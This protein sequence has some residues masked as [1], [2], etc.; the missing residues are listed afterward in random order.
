MYYRYT[1]DQGTESLILHGD[2]VSAAVPSSHPR[3]AELVDYLR[4]RRDHDAGH[5]RRLLDA[6]GALAARL[7]RLSERVAFDGTHLRFDGD[8]IDT[9][10]SRHIIRMMRGGDESYARWVMFLENLAENQSA[11]SRI[12]LFTWLDGRDFAITPDGHLLGYK[13][14]Q[15][16]EH[17]SS[18]HAGTAIVN[19]TW[20]H[21]HIPN[22]VGATV[23]M[24]RNQVA[25]DRAAGC[26]TGLH[27]GTHAYANGYGQRLLL[28]AVNPRDVVSVPRDCS[29][30]KLRC[31]R[32]T[33]LGVHDRLGPIATPSYGDGGLFPREPERASR[34]HV[35]RPHT[36]TDPGIAWHL[37]AARDFIRRAA[38]E[39]HVIS[40][41]ERDRYLAMIDTE[42][43][44][45][46]SG[47]ALLTAV[48]ER[49]IEVYEDGS[50]CHDALNDFLA[51]AGLDLHDE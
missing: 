24:P 7:R 21:G 42:E 1:N 33:V 14:V 45:A 36:G 44:R 38:D 46:T 35:S 48:R 6:G 3:F 20:H 8:V 43:R 23:E 47:A 27:V 13:G 9:S 28:V 51:A 30:Q 4:S 16:D 5:V 22:P 32:Y 39:C 29:Y 12:H 25:A 18:I 15:A 17:N 2:G 50:I 40:A 26:A 31:C 10:L 49:A 34:G 19:G 41:S 11:L 37:Q